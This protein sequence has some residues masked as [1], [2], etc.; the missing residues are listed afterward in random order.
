MIKEK[1]SK[2][3]IN[4]IEKKYEQNDRK[5]IKV[6]ELV[7][8]FYK[9]I[10]SGKERIQTYK[11]LIIGIQNKGLGKSFTL[12]RKIDGIGS[13]QIFLYHSPKIL[14]ITKEYSLKFRRSKLYYLRLLRKELKL[15]K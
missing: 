3:F 9:N 8:I 2:D 15:L 1:I 12:R 11:G 10:E 4:L 5:T 14:S 13:E 6:G 7:K